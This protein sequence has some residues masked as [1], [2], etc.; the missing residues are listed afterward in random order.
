MK[1]LSV[2][3][4]Q[5]PRSLGKP[6]GITGLK[7]WQT[8]MEKMR[9]LTSPWAS[10]IAQLVKNLP[11]RQETPVQF[12]GQE[13]LLR[14][15]RLPTPVFL[16]FPCGSAG[17]ESTSNLG[18]LGSFQHSGLENSTDCMVHRVAKSWARK[19]TFTLPPLMWFCCCQG[20]GKV[21]IN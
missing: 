7:P 21:Y 20:N 11:S 6:W 15:D 10:Q 2:T 18:D 1:E 12:L 14:R 3:H 4:S 13:D 17:K 19:A 8:P 16:G 5:V 9:S